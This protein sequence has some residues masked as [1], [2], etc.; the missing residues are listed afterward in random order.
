MLTTDDARST[1]TVSSD[2]HPDRRLRALLHPTERSRFALALVAVVLV[3]GARLPVG[4]VR[5]ARQPDPQ[6]SLNGPQVRSKTGF[7][8]K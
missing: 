8:A 3:I 1:F 5:Q 4:S 2:R 6:D 7:N